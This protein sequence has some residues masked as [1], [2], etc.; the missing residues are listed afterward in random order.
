M[1]KS[2]N[3][4]D[5]DEVAKET[6]S[7]KS[8]PEED[9]IKNYAE[10]TMNELLGLF[11]YEDK[12][13]STDTENLNLENYTE[14]NDS[15][16]PTSEVNGDV[17]DKK[18]R[19]SERLKSSLRRRLLPLDDN[20]LAQQHMNLVT[21]LKRRE[22]EAGASADAESRAENE[23]S[24]ECAWCRKPG[25]KQISL[26][27]P[28]GSK[29][30][31]SEVCFTQCRR[32]SFK[33]SKTC[34]WCKHVRHTV[35]YVEFQDGETQ[36]QFCSE[37]CLNQYKMSIFCKETQ[38][39]LQKMSKKGDDSS[40]GKDEEREI[41]IT[42]ELW[43]RSEQARR[44]A[45]ARE[46]ARERERQE[47][48]EDRE[49]CRKTFSVSAEKLSSH[50]INNKSDISEKSRLSLLDRIKSEAKHKRSFSEREPDRTSPARSEPQAASPS[51]KSE[52]PFPA[53]ML[54][55]SI[56]MAP[57]LHQAHLMGAFPPGLMPY[58]H[59]PPVMLAGFIPPPQGNVVADNRD[60]EEPEQDRRTSKKEHTTRQNHFGLLSPQVSGSTQRHES[61][62]LPSLNERRTSSL[63]PVDFPQFFP[64]QTGSSTAAEAAEQPSGIPG[65]PPVTVMIPI[66]VP[67]PLPVPIPI[68]IPLTMNQLTSFFGNTEK[69]ENNDKLDSTSPLP[70]INVETTKGSRSPLPVYIQSPKSVTSAGS[71]YNAYDKLEGRSGS[72]NSCPDLSLYVNVSD[73][74]VRRSESHLYKRSRTP[75]SMRSLDLSRTSKIPRYEYNSVTSD[76]NDGVIDLSSTRE[77]GHRSED[78]ASE[79]SVVNGNV[80]EESSLSRDDNDNYTEDGPLVP[81]IHIITHRNESPL[82]QPLPLPPTEN[83]YSSRRGLILDAPVIAKKSRSPSPERRSYVRN[84]PR[85]I[86]EAARRR[87][88]RARIR[89]K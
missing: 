8:E 62:I 54:H 31:C 6:V 18:R 66:P 84:V 61:R 28:T 51:P 45:E 46:S 59:M 40:G 72:R 3:S 35:N 57:W 69:S 14:N 74:R 20:A 49:N 19:P 42:P 34:D 56:A 5:G 33:K 81:K 17:K 1:D 76:S 41:L 43:M 65:I 77:N 68:P 82:N 53:H 87:C 64:G 9:T 2:E 23:S 11:G 86:I 83:S 67:L 55:P 37:K 10:H 73:S 85:E 16:A 71:D 75:E 70:K 38:E 52:T 13:N 25:N 58:S 21:A 44:A 7:V 88:M 32:A 30:F 36:L 78:N 22:L 26:D 80:N 39:H 47:R 4:A 63:F 48:R 60:K 50:K 12:V 15:D 29:V 79:C 27:T 24:Q 89:T